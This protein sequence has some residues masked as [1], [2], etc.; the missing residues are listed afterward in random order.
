MITFDVK[1]DENNGKENRG[2]R[3]LSFVK[4]NSTFVTLLTTILTTLVTVLATNLYKLCAYWF[5][6]GR[7]DYFNIPSEFIKI[8]YEISIWEFLRVASIVLVVLLIIFFHCMAFYRVQ[9]KHKKLKKII[10][11]GLIILIAPIT[12][13]VLLIVYVKKISN[14]SIIEILMDIYMSPKVYVVC[15]ILGVVL[16]YII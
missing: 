10:L 3:V 1:N 7:Y 2:N 5:Y 14:L 4:E 8:N 11:S 15:L 9:H 16:Y 13:G 6:K 12:I